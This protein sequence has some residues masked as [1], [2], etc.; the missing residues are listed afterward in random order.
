MELDLNLIHICKYLIEFNLD[1][2]RE[3]LKKIFFHEKI[4]AIRI[5]FS[6][7]DFQAHY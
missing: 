6:F 3:I 4:S 1:K 7:T 2:C 5:L